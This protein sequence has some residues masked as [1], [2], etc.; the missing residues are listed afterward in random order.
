MPKRILE[1]K[2]LS[3][4]NL[5]TVVI[6]V[7]RRFRH[8]LYKKAVTKSKK[9]H[10]HDEKCQYKVNDFIKIIESRPYS[11]TKRFEVIY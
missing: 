4:S 5:K 9:Y 6:E 3:A 11:K 1:G 2:V 7:E 10:A 8:P